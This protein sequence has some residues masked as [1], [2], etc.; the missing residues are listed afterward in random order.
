MISFSKYPIWCLIAFLALASCV[1]DET[2]PEPED[3]T[4]PINTT[5]PFFRWKTE[6]GNLVESDSSVCFVQSGVVFGYKNGNSHT[7]EARLISMNAGT[8]QISSSTGNEVDYFV[9]NKLHTGT[10]TFVITEST[11]TT[12]SGNFTCSLS[13]GT[14][15]SL[16]GTFAAV[17]KRYN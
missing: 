14:L 17:P 9:N 10:G 11:S 15:T 12:I 13:G 16:S 3:P 1:K 8:Y 5:P 7:V 6:P 4:T 2:E